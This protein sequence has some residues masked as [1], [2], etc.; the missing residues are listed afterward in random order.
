M[1]ASA[2]VMRNPASSHENGAARRSCHSS[3]V[4]STHLNSEDHLMSEDDA[5]EHVQFR[6]LQHVLDDADLLAARGS[7]RT[8]LGGA[9]SS[10]R[11]P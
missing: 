11:P 4:T 10:R 9:F 1:I 7:D 6:D 5:V 3:R 8:P 2:V